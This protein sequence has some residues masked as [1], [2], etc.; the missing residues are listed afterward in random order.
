MKTHWVHDYETLA[1][2][3]VGVFRSINSD[4][5]RIFVIHDLR[6]DLPE[7]IEFLKQNVKQ[8]EWH[9]SYNGLA[10]DGQIT[11]YIIRS[12]EMLLDMSG[13]EVGTWIY[14]RA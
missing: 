3:F 5:I 11:Q 10:F 1:N 6:N 4:N 8:K 14:E 7:F 2:C 13:C 9:V 12:S